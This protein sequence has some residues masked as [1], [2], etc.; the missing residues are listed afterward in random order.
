VS[1]VADSPLQESPRQYFRRHLQEQTSTTRDLLWYLEQSVPRFSGSAEVRLAVE[2]LADRLGEFLCFGVARGEGD[3]YGIWTSARGPRLV[4][5]VES[6][7]RVVARMA[8]IAHTRTRLL[9]SLDVSRDDDLS[10]LCVL[11]GAFDERLLNEAVALRRASRE[12]RLVSTSSLVS[13]AES[14]EAGRL[15]HADVLTLLRPA[16]VLADGVI[17]IAGGDTVTRP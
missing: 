5:W 2:E 16:S 9:G 15:S 7:T 8:T 4:V 13:L 17:G 14:V 11:A 12:L 1:L 6:A 10:C 3:D